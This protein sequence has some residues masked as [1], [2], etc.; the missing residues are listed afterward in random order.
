MKGFSEES[1]MRE[2]AE[3]YPPGWEIVNDEDAA[4][5]KTFSRTRIT[6]PDNGL[7]AFKL[8]T[9]RLQIYTMD[10]FLTQK[11]CDEVID[12]IMPYLR[13]FTVTREN[14]DKAYRTSSTSDM[15]LMTKPHEKNLVAMLDEKISRAIGIR[16]PYSEGIQAQRYVVGQEFK[17]HTDFFQP[18]GEEYKKY[19]GKRG[20][21]TWTFMIYL[22]RVTRGG[23]TRFLAI[24]KDIQPQ[25]G[26]AVIWNNLHPDGSGNSDALHAGT[27]R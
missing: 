2:M 3:D 5:Y 14:E 16:L 25:R 24:D 15:V 12:V 9:D 7:N 1:I 10:D 23:S 13:P 20:Q 27:G 17:R 21:R 4:T 26:R 22:N 6:Q 8:D 11:E 19:A 18:G